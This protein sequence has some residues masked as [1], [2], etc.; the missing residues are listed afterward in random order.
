MGTLF[1]GP[2]VSHLLPHS[3]FLPRQPPYFFFSPS[4]LSPSFSKLRSS[5]LYAAAM[6]VRRGV[7]GAQGWQ[8]RWVARVAGRQNVATPAES[9]VAKKKDGAAL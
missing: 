2:E 9:L 6:S 4:L 5:L 8:G 7:E 1:Q 3:L